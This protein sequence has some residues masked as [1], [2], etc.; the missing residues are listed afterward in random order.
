MSLIAFVWCMT[1]SLELAIEDAQ[2][3]FKN[4]KRF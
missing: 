2:K 1:H 4:S 3:Y